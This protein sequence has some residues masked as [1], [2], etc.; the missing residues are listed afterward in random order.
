MR[1][2]L[3]IILP[4]DLVLVIIDHYY[5]YLSSLE[6]RASAIFQGTS[7]SMTFPGG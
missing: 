1:D 6:L 7:E 4:E 2:P 5:L 3:M